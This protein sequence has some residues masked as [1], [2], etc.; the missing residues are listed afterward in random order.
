MKNISGEKQS[1][2][3]QCRQDVANSLIVWLV[4]FL[5]KSTNNRLA[6]K[7]IEVLA[8]VVELTKGWSCTPLSVDRK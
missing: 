5:G 6:V 1:R 3:H 4:T 7:N 2:F 8:A